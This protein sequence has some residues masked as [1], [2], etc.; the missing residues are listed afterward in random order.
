MR[1]ECTLNDG[2]PVILRP[3]HCDDLPACAEFFA[4]C[5]PR[6]LYS[7]YERLRVES[8]F[9]LAKQLC[10]ADQDTQLA[11]VGETEIDGLDRVIGIAQLLSDPRH[12][13]AEF[14]VL[15]ADAWQGLGLGSHFADFS[16]ALAEAWGVER[17]V[18]EFLPDNVRLIRIVESRSFK[19]CRDGSGQVVSAQKLLGE[20]GRDG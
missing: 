19:L 13:V 12:E 5:S 9:E 17:L 8:P 2:T 4:C 7:R 11:M 1:C 14:A 16:L 6:S 3:L 15:V 20:R 10:F 18:A